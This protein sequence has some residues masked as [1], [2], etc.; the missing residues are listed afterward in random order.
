MK[1]IGTSAGIALGKVLVYKEPEIKI[2]KKTIDDLE[3]EIERLDTAIEQ[4]I[5][6]LE[7]LYEETLENIGEEEAE[8]FN[9]HKM[10]IQDP[11]YIDGI[12]GKIKEEKVNVE[13]ALKE[14]TD[15][16]VSLF[17]NI[18]D[19]YLRERALDLKDIS[20]RLIR[21]LYG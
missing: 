3:G 19:E 16:Y 13:W 2:E 15:Q 8:I 1:A 9:A 7:N 12:K 10:M 17:E 21:I 6:E 4:G 11:E 5:K 14:V 20:Q 18:D